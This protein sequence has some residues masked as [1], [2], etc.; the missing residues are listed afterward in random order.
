M[1]EMERAAAEFV[2]KLD[3]AL[4]DDQ[5]GRAERFGPDGDYV[6]LARRLQRVDTSTGSTLRSDLRR[7]LLQRLE[8]KQGRRRWHSP[9]TQPFG[10]VSRSAAWALWLVV[11]LLALGFATPAARSAAEAVQE[12]FQEIRWPHTT[13]RQMPAAPTPSPAFI[14]ELRARFEREEA[15]GRAWSYHFEGSN[16]GGCCADGMRNEAVSLEQA[17]DETG[18][19]ILLPG[20]VPEGY[21]LTEVRLLGLPPYAVFAV[22]EGPNGPFGLYQAGVGR[23]E[24]VAGESAVVTARETIFGTSGTLEEV[25]VGEVTAALT[26]EQELVWEENGTSFVLVGPG[27]NVETLVEIAESLAPAD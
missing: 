27:F 2:Q 8:V 7:E 5:P 26:E 13:A 12:F 17:I 14:Q 3:E 16:F 9:F 11:L 21:A 6:A 20:F 15:A 10:R 4:L 23:T 19:A 24:E 18:G 1:E 22:F 25:V